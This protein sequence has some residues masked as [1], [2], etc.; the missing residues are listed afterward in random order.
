[1]FD[2]AGDG[3]T[4]LRLNRGLFQLLRKEGVHLS[5]STAGKVEGRVIT[6]PIEAGQVD[7]TTGKGSV[8]LEGGIELWAGRRRVAL[9]GLNFDSGRRTLTGKI[10][11]RTL[12]IA[13]AFGIRSTRNGFG[14]NIDVKG[15][16]MR[17]TAAKILNR[18][19]GLDGVIRRNRTFAEATTYAQP[20]AV[21]IVS[22]SL[23]LA[24]NEETFAKLKSLDVRVTP[25]ESATLL[26]ESPPTFGFPLLSGGA[27]VPLDLSSGGVRSETGLMLIQ[28][29]GSSTPTVLSL[30]GL[31][32][33]LESKLIS[34]DVSVQP[35]SSGVSRF[36]VTPIATLDT[37]GASMSI[38]PGAR[39]IT[40]ANVSA[41]ITQFLA[42]RL[43]DAFAKPQ[44]KAPLFDAGEP[45][46]TVTVAVQAQ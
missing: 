10:G 44:G 28:Q 42:E 23:A 7:P 8:S 34:A 1:A 12:L 3:S 35:Q 5:K 13:S 21:T 11:T 2:P 22:G 45:L 46:G 31:S 24:G 36:G 9:T 20:G 18:K 19:L 4:V 41:T 15:L 29:G 39:T 30:M 26:S 37:P 27:P 17:S 25:F 14:A 6:L 43:N 16:A 38:D 32:V 33:S 40:L